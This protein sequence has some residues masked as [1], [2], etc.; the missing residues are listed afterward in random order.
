[1]SERA[2]RDKNAVLYRES[3]WPGIKA[4]LVRHIEAA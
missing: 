3:Q 2:G 4:A 1:M